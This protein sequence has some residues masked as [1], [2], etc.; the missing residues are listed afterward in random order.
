MSI[1]EL[2]DGPDITLMLSSVYF[3]DWI[4]KELPNITSLNFGILTL[5]EKK[6][7]SGLSISLAERGKLLETTLVCVERLGYITRFGMIFELLVA[8]SLS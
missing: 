5:R 7:E 3:C 2:I 6:F 8:L 4:G 1:R